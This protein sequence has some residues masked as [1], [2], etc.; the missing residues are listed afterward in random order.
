MNAQWKT[1]EEAI[2]V[3]GENM[4]MIAKTFKEK[5]K[6]V[7]NAELHSQAAGFVM[8]QAFAPKNG[9]LPVEPTSANYC[10]MFHAL[11]NQSAWRQKWEKAG[12]FTKATSAKGFEGAM[13]ELEEEFGEKE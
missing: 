4:E 3:A 11:Y 6:K 2:K 8:R 1:V 13:D 5:G 9:E 10:A 12:Y 7:Y